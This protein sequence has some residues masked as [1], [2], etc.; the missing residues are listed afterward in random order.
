MERK[1]NQNF[2]FVQILSQFLLYYKY[3]YKFITN[4][5]Y[6]IKINLKLLVLKSCKLTIIPPK[7]QTKNEEKA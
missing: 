7:E 1:I 2:N 3:T 4:F 5:I 6:Q